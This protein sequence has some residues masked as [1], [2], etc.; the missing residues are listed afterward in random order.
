MNHSMAA[1]MAS[2]PHS[3][4]LSRRRHQPTVTLCNCSGDMMTT[5]HLNEG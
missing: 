3:I 5:N 2:L 1:P 4:A